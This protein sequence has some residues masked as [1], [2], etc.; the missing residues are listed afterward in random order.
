MGLSLVKNFSNYQDYKKKSLE[1][2]FEKVEYIVIRD[3]NKETVIMAKK[4]WK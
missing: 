4:N 3:I 2:I 1:T